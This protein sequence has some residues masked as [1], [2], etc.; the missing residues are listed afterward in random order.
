MI[1]KLS[2]EKHMT[3]IISSHILEELSKIATDYGIIHR[4]VLLQ[5]LSREEVMK[6]CC[7]RIEITMDQPRQAVPILDSMGFAN[8]L[9]VDSEHVFIYERMEES[10]LLNRELNQSDIYVKEIKIRNEE[11]GNY[12]FTLLD[13]PFE[14]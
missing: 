10:A 14:V 13:K 11:L 1:L 8:Y 5:E 3:I 2:E 12:F 4:G 7:E 6:K 9:I